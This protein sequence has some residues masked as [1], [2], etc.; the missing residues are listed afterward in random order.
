MEAENKSR[1]SNYMRMLSAL[2]SGPTQFP[3]VASL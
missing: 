1:L 3:S 2:S